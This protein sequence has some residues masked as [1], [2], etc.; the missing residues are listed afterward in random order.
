MEAIFQIIVSGLTLGAM[1]ALGSVGLALTYGTM[2]MFNMAHGVF[3]A[4]GAYGAFFA[5][6]V[7]GLPILLA[8]LGGIVL[9][10]VVGA[11]L[12]LLVVRFMLDTKDFEINILVATAGV[13]I[14]LQDLLLK[15]FGAY[16]FRQPVQIEG[17]VELGGV[18]IP[19]QSLAILFVGFT[20]I[21]AIAWGLTRTSFGLSIRATAMNRDAARLM[22]VNATATYLQVLIIAGMLA[23]AAGVMISSISTLS[24]DMG[25]NPAIRA[26]VICVVAGLG[27]VGGAGITALALGLIEAAVQYYI[28]ARF[29]LPLMLAL[30]VI[31]LVRRPAGLFGREEVVR[32]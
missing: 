8:L 25:T 4:I 19:V 26:F 7:L 17:T 2:R 20:L 32:S 12:H 28:G 29:G 6:D 30:V 27:S 5:A 10:G 11:L 9:G 22:G 15:L 3:M 13:G 24:P 31:V 23:G 18:V 14:L 21:S 16:P 1:Y